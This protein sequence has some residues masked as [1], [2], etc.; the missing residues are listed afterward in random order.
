METRRLIT[1]LTGI[2]VAI[3]LVIGG[4]VVVSSM[5][6]GDD[7]G[8]GGSTTNDGGDDGGDSGQPTPNLPERAGSCGCSD[9]TR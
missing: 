5:G 7:D 1:I 3:V 8:G 4:L 2:A 6:G 9:P